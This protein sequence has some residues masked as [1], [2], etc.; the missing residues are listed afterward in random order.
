M[1]KS[2]IIIAFVL[3]ALLASC[4]ENPG[5]T[6]MRLHLALG[7]ESNSKTLSPNDS[8][9]LDVSKYTI[10]GTG[11]N[12]K[13]FTTSS[14]SDSVTID[15]LTIGQWT[16][17]A[18]GLNNQNTEIVSGTLTFTLT[19]TPTPQTIVLDTLIG[20][21]S[22]SFSVDWAACDVASPSVVAYLKG[23]DMN[24]KEVELPVTLNKDNK[25]AYVS[26]NLAAGSYLLR[27]LLYDDSVQVAG[28]VEA[29]R[30]S[31]GTESNGTLSFLFNELGAQ[32]VM[33]IK[34]ATGVPIKGVL[35]MEGSPSEFVA[36]TEYTCNFAFSSPE[37]VQSNGLTIEWYYDGAL[38][39]DS[40]RSLDSTG[41]SFTVTPTV[42]AHRIDAVVYNT[43]LG[44]TGSAS[45]SFNVIPN[46]HDGELLLLNEN[47]H[48][49][50]SIDE[51]TLVAALPNDKFVVIS[52]T[53]GEMYVCSVSSSAQTLSVEKTYSAS[54]ASGFYWIAATK[55]LFSDQKMDYLIATDNYQGKESVT[56]LRL[57]SSSNTLTSCLRAESK[58]GSVSLS[59]ISAATFTP[60]KNF[61]QIADS[62]TKYMF[63]LTV[64][65]NTAK[66]SA[67]NKKIGSGA[68]E[69][70]NDLDSS[71]DGKYLLYS[72][73]S[74]TGFVSIS[75]ADE[76]R[77][78]NGSVS[79]LG[80]YATK[81]IRY[82]N[83]SLVI[84]AGSTCLETYKVVEGSSYTKMSTFDIPVEKLEADGSNYFYV[85]STGNRIESFEAIGY[86]ISSIGSVSLS[87][88][89]L[90]VALSENYFVTVTANGAI[91]LLGII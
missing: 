30:I 51:K 28:L 18:K 21:G 5:T 76:G 81:G 69:S 78:L 20:T 43:K 50:L 68:F 57:D 88:A 47:A 90:S 74:S 39:P 42:G 8:S 38:Q 13:T 72:A 19:S 3:M 85:V 40:P 82:A 31:N 58:M 55:H 33:H 17:T 23:P 64:D 4:S 35:S 46:G 22:F 70:V 73:A 15:G 25:T 59:E 87:A 77:L 62:G 89:P 56:C 86:A 7:S 61:I 80:L 53:V 54:D 16:V 79:E 71:P 34:D 29:V 36:Q 37:N 2:V 49:S 91:S 75:Y 60:S 11:P 12:G 63:A 52:P 24:Q 32:V 67:Y 65:G 66:L 10:T 6:T 41:S 1:R 48:G 45:Y 27:V 9:V 14:S 83:A 26:E 44:S 84:K